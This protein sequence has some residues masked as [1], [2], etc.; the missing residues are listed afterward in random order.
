MAPLRWGSLP[1]PVLLRAPQKGLSQSQHSEECSP[2]CFRSLQ[3][4]RVSQTHTEKQRTTSQLA[5]PY[6]PPGLQEDCK[7]LREQVENGSS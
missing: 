5:A 6:W 2:S 3:L 7:V 4:L 1:W